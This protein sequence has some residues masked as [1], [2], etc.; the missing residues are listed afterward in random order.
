MS[1]FFLFKDGDD[2]VTSIDF[3]SFIASHIDKLQTITN[4]L[5]FINLGS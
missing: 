4:D 2:V 5:F 1:G 3:I